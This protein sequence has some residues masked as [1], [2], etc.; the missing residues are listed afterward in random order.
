MYTILI[1]KRGKYNL[2]YMHGKC[3][4]KTFDVCIVVF[5][6]SLKNLG[7]TTLI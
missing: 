7:S 2:T 3:Y 4:F 5:L 1:C 6:P